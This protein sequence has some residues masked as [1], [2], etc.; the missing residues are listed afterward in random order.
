MTIRYNIIKWV[1]TFYFIYLKK[2]LKR[3]EFDGSI[4]RASSPYS[5]AI[6]E[7]PRSFRSSFYWQR[8]NGNSV[9]SQLRTREQVRE[10]VKKIIKIE[11]ERWCE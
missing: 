6:F 1:C 4:G 9:C 2:I 5:T 8:E 7:F 3:L 11:N 10:I